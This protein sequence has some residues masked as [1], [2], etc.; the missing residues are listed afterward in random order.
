MAKIVQLVEN[1][2]K[3]F[4]RTHFKAVEGFDGSVIKEVL[5]VAEFNWQNL[6]L[7]SGFTVDGNRTP[8]YKKIQNLDGSIL[9]KLRGRISGAFTSTGKVPFKVPIDVVPEMT[10]AFM[11]ATSSSQYARGSFEV[12]GSFTVSTDANG[13]VT[14]VD[15]S[16]VFYVVEGGK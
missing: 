2:E 1:G 7:N 16:G 6:S 10:E 5:D 3:K 4:L 11:I 13:G 8:Q 12:D 15:I 14:W 9:V